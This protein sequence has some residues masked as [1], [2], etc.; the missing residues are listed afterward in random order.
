[1]FIYSVVY[2]QTFATIY[3]PEGSRAAEAH[4]VSV[5]RCIVYWLFLRWT[6]GRLRIW[7]GGGHVWMR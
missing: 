2:I 6:W 4:D 1:M 3:G 5:V 7:T